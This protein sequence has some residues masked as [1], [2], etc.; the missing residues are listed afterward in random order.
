MA[1]LVELAGAAYPKDAT[2]LEGKSLV[3]AFADRPIDRDALFWEHE[4]NRAV[5]VGDWKAVAKGRAA[6]G[7]V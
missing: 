6:L 4:G 5:R 3:P 2:P 7:A 1:T